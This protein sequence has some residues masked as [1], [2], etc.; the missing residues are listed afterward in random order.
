MLVFGLCGLGTNLALSWNFL[1]RYGF[2]LGPLDF[3][4]SSIY[5]TAI[6]KIV[7]PLELSVFLQ[8][9]ALFVGDSVNL[10]FQI[11]FITC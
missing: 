10:S 9:F 6:I 1:F 5:F 11:V 3:V 4:A 2:L 8:F 7:A